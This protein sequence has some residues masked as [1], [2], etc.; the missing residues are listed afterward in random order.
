[1]KRVSHYRKTI[2]PLQVACL[3]LWMVVGAVA[4][5]G[6]ATLLQTEPAASA[7]LPEAP[8]QVTLWFDQR[9]E[10]IFNSIRVVDLQGQRMDT[11]QPNVQEQGEAVS[12]RLKSLS[13]GGYWVLWRVSS[14]DGHTVQGKFSFGV[15]SKA[16][17]PDSLPAS[18]IAEKN[19][20]QSA[21]QVAMKWASLMGAVFWLGGIGFLTGVL[22]PAL[23][24]SSE[25]P[26]GFAQ[27]ATQRTLRL[28]WTGAIVWIVA[29]FLSLIRQAAAIADA[30]F[31]ETLS[32]SVLIPVLSSTNYGHWWTARMLCGVALIGLCWQFSQAGYFNAARKRQDSWTRPL[33]HFSTAAL[34]G[35]MLL[36]APMT[37]HAHAVGQRTIVAVFSDWVHL[38]ASV[39]WTGGLIYFLAVVL[40]VTREQREATLELSRLARRFSHVARVCVLLIVAS[41]VYNALLH[42]PAWGSFLSADY[43]RVLLAKLIVLVPMLLIAAVNWRW[44]LPAMAAVR[45]Q[46]DRGRRWVSRF[47][48]LLRGEAALGVVILALVAVLTSLPPASTVS[49]GGPVSQSKQAGN[50]TVVL[51]LSPNRVGTNQAVVSLKNSAGLSLADARRVKVYLRMMDMEMGL[52]TVEAQATPEGNYQADV[53][54]SMTGRWSVSVEVTPAEGDAFVTE[55]QISP[56]Q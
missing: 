33:V 4:A 13:T 24:E 55:F 25:P 16:P 15:Q 52:E 31:R 54:I 21:F 18:M 41:G 37:G 20:G 12:I 26:D 43:G 51:N 36:A 27:V 9:V 22:L 7:S 48:G 28:L 3:A 42:M 46:P 32:A 49:A 35:V 53:P 44:V 50:M 2:A 39:V 1:M 34:A 45:E 17:A 10:P 30:S 11:G 6:H 47:R 19:A 38:S 5:W 23:N 56:S 14:V 8:T 40:A 29:E